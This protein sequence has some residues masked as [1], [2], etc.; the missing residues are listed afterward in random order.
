MI[1]VLILEDSSERIR[2]FVER[3]GQCDL[4]ITEDAAEA[5]DYLRGNVFN[6]VFLDNDLGENNGEGIDVAEFLHNNP[7]NLNNSS[8]IIIHSWNSPAARIMKGLLPASKIIPFNK[9]NFLSLG[10]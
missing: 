10:V 6:Y 3:L 4:T 9:N 8:N 1:K 5:V 7:T 2:F